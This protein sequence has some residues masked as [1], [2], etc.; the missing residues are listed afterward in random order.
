LTNVLLVGPWGPPSLAFA[1]S[2]ARRGVGVY[3]LQASSK[4]PLRQFHPLRGS[5]VMSER[6]VGKDEGLERIKQYAR[7]I[8]ASALVATV[9]HELLWI[10]EHRGEFEPACRV[11]APP[12]DALRMG[13]SKARQLRVATE[14]G[15][16]V[17]PTTLVRTEDDVAPIPESAFPLVI[18]PDRPEGIEPEFKMKLVASS[19]QLRA[20]VR[21]CRRID[22]P[23]LAQPFR[24]LP[25]LLVHG[26]RS[27][28]GESLAMRCYYVPRKFEGVTLALEPMSFPEGLEVSCRTFADRAGITGC[29]HLEFLFSPSEKRAYFLEVNVRLGGTTDK[30]VKTGYDEPAL[31][32]EAYRMI[33]RGSSTARTC[34]GRVVNKRVV[35]KH[36][37]WAAAGK[38]TALDY[39]HGSRLRNIAS[40]CRDLIA[41]TDSIF[42][43]RDVP[44]SIRFH[45]RG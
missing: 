27:V 26:A 30:V 2:A 8:G 23:I 25:N 19:E 29:Y 41:A 20:I 9:D 36:I 22:A 16:D 45:L 38:L 40:S 44:G 28:D 35:L 11:L 43:W 10:A 32:L 4:H 3:L 34:V 1:R 33:P 42:D 37:A 13:L 12:V 31:L 17:L 15:L 5:A 18:R 21:E 7:G 6:L 24:D 39:P 14:A